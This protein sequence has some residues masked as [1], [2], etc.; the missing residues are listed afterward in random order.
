M[1]ATRIEDYLARVDRHLETLSGGGQREFLESLIDQWTERY[2]D[3]QARV[4]RGAPTPAGTTAFDYINTLA[5]LDQRQSTATAEACAD[6]RKWQAA[7]RK[8]AGYRA[9]V[10]QA[11]E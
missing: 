4:D 3:W 5:G 2:R 7:Y 10:M 11:A 6:L 1:S 9:P 8:S